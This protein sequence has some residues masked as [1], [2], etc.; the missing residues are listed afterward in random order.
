M[1]EDS[2]ART[3]TAL[4]AGL[5]AGDFTVLL[6]LLADHVQWHGAGPGGCRSRGEV[7]A[8][9]QGFSGA[10]I[11]LRALRRVADR[12]VLQVAVSPGDDVHQL[13][14]LDDAGRITLVLQHDDAAAAECD[15]VPAA[16][17]T[18][19]VA[20]DRLVPIAR[21]ADVEASIAFYGVLGFGVTGEHRHHERRVWASL[22][23]GAAELMVEEAEDAVDVAAQG[24]LFYLYTD[25]LAGLREHLR[26]HGVTSS[27]IADGRPG[28][29]RE[30]RVDDPD[31]YCLMIAER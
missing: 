1:G 11:V 20:V 7:A 31:G 25:D 15:L 19:A 27:A 10:T 14:V 21:V 8:M 26:A 12:I 24:V 9:I 4:R 3:E 28:P 22:R 17:G 23:S 29:E 18:P 5:D 2:W 16:S 30:M 6:P 13:V